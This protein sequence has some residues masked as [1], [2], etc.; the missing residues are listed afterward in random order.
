MGPAPW[1]RFV[2]CGLSGFALAAALYGVATFSPEGCLDLDAS[3][4]PGMLP[5]IVAFWVTLGLS[6]VALFIGLV[7]V[8]KR[9]RRDAEARSHA[10]DRPSFPDAESLRLWNEQ[11]PKPR[12]DIHPEAE[13]PSDVTS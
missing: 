10:M 6:C 7:G 9:V 13:P 11:R 12:T 8:I 1:S 4:R 2:V 5:V 3:R